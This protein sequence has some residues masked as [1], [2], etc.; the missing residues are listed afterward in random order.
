MTNTKAGFKTILS[1]PVHY[2][3]GTVGSILSQPSSL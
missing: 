1:T 2:E 3:I